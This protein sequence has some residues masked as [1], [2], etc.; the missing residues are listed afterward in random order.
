MNV[1]MTMT[2]AGRLLH[3]VSDLIRQAGTSA[4]KFLEGHGLFP[5]T[6]VQKELSIL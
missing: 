1:P 5:L 4:M 2:V 6:A 3:T